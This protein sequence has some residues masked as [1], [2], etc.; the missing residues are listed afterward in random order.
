MTDTNS[1][2]LI[3]R[4]TKDVGEKDFGYTAGGLAKLETSIAVNSDVKR[5]GEWH[6]EVSYFNITLWGKSAENLKQ[7]LTKGSQVA[8]TG[9][10]QQQRWSDKNGNNQ[11][12][13]AIVT[14]NI[15]LLGSRKD[16]Q[17]SAPAPQQQ[18][19]PA[20][21]EPQQQEFPEDIPF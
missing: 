9:H 4:I 5:N 18:S 10:L 11:S 1:I 8:V 16:S 6:G 21:A 19:A 7:Y 13:I 3:G 20:Q 14:E 15:Q 17:G 12:K 2:I